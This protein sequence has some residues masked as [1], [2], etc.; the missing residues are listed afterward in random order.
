MDALWMQCRRFA[1]VVEGAAYQGRRDR[2]HMSKNYRQRAG[3]SSW[4][5]RLGG[6]S[7]LNAPRAGQCHADGAVINQRV[8]LCWL[9]CHDAEQSVRRSAT[10]RG[11][12]GWTCCRAAG[13]DVLIRH[14]RSSTRA[15]PEIRSNMGVER[16][17]VD[18]I[19]EIDCVVR[20]GEPDGPC[21]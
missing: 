15:I 18:M 9:K 16:S 8:I 11:R 19:D 7:C 14:C 13:P 4:R 6:S 3:A 10:P 1:R 5:P 17:D 20:G 2:L 12:H 21:R